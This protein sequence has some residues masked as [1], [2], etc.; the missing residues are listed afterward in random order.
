ML[1]KTSL[2][3]YIL[4]T[5]LLVFVL[6]ML[7]TCGT[8]CATQAAYNNLPEPVQTLIDFQY[9][10]YYEEDIDNTFSLYTTPEYA[11]KN[12]DMYKGLPGLIEGFAP[13]VYEKAKRSPLSKQ[14]FISGFLEDHEWTIEGDLATIYRK[15]ELGKPEKSR[16]CIFLKLIDGKW[17]VCA[18]S[19]YTL[20]IL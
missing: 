3:N 18:D 19:G 13:V 7:I 10:I 15:D 1:N 9:M 8:S 4:S 2:P 5:S 16:K 6:S 17:L 14:K 12:K 20:K 11:Q